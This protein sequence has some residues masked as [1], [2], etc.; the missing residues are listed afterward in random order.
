MYTPKGSMAKSEGILVARAICSG[1]VSAARALVLAYRWSARTV[2]EARA[3]LGA[4]RFAAAAYGAKL[5][6]QEFLYPPRALPQAA[7]ALPSA[8]RAARRPVQSWGTVNGVTGP[9]HIDGWG[10]LRVGG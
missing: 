6:P 7:P 5:D 8:K 10:V 2:P 9:L 4:C 1:D 3:I